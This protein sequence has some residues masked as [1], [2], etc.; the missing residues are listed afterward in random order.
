[1]RKIILITVFV[2]I[3]AVTVTAFYF[4]KLKLPGQ[5]TTNLIN[6]I[7]ED[8]A[9]VFEFKNDPEF[10]DLFR[11][12]T[13]LTSFIG[14]KKVNELQYLHQQLTKQTALKTAFNNRS[15]FISFHPEIE[16]GNLDMLMLINADGVKDLQQTL[17]ALTTHSDAALE[18]EKIGNKTV[19]H[20]TFPA[21]KEV[22]YLTYNAEVVA[23]SFNKSLLLHFLDERA[24]KKV[25]NLTQ[26]SDQQ[27][28]NSIAN[29]YV[30]YHR[31]PVLFQQL[32]RNQN[33]DFFRFLNGFPASAALSLNY[34]TD[35]LLFNGF[36]Q[37]DTAAAAYVNLFLSQQPEKNTL[38]NIYPAN[39]ASAVGFAYAKPASFFSALDLWQHK[40][41]QEGKA[42]ALF[43]QIKRETGV[44]I[45]TAFRKQLDKEF[46]VLTTAESE[47][48]AIIKVK[49]GS[50]LEPF[51][52]N[53]SQNP[54]SEKTRL[55]YDN[56]PY[57]LLGEPFAHFKQPYFVLIDNY[58][59]LSNSENG[60]NHY[61]ANYHQQQFLTGEKAYYEFDQLL[62]EQSNVSFFVHFKNAF[63]IFQT[64]LQPGF[65]AAFSKKQSGWTNYFAGALQFTASQNNFYTNFCLKQIEA[66]TSKSDSTAF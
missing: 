13:L 27:N 35:A 15:I 31:F 54:D 3:T 53:I 5:N 39:T 33:D 24:D 14:Q 34:K 52:R 65:R 30:N 28:K 59:F 47:K 11:E 44:S 10:Y 22:F 60:L 25:S 49:N 20:L 19:Q 63:Q 18:P 21:L 57:Y 62:A 64:N 16:S 36:T 50:E 37:T 48:I 55:K 46:A 66:K 17:N 7:P 61:L 9:L 56:L 45:K 38:K 29:L 42:K 51:L 32:F 58:L 1:M 12:S 8:A 26:L 40:S 41:K 43:N 2:F 23:G 4:A 6:Q